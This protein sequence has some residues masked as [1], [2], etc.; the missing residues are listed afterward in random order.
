EFAGGAAVQAVFSFESAIR[1]TLLELTG[2]SGSMALPDPNGFDKPNEVWELG[3]QE[4]AVIEAVGSPAPPRVG[5]CVVPPARHA[6][7]PE[8]A[9][10]QLAYHVLDVMIS[11]AEAAESGEA[12]QID[13]TAAVP[14]LLPEGWD[15]AAATL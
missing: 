11:I 3:A 5:L 14:P 12:V 1:R 2:T 8:R 15:P 13:S 7:G 9:S 10:G 4:P 6:G